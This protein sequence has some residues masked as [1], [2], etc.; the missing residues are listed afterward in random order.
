MLPLKL[1]FDGDDFTSAFFRSNVSFIE[2]SIEDCD[3]IIGTGL[4]FGSVIKKDVQKVLDKYGKYS[5]K[6]VLFFV[7]DFE[8]SLHVPSN[9]LLF[10]TSILKSLKKE[11]EFIL[12]YIWEEIEGITFQTLPK[13]NQPI[14]GFCGNIKHNIGKRLTTINKFK[15]DTRFV[16]KFILRQGFWGGKPNDVNYKTDYIENIKEAHFSICNRGKG[17]FT[18]RLY[19]VLSLGRIPILI[20]SDM[21]YPFEDLINWDEF[22]VKAKKQN[23]LLEKTFNFWDSKNN[24]QLENAQLKAKEIFDNYFTPKAFGNK[25]GQLL[26]NHKNFVPKTT[27]SKRFNFPFLNFLNKDR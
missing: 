4:V 3:Y 21:I 18:I 10:R 22:M 8:K 1:F 5:K 14:V 20:D 15:S 24:S 19:Q 2:T 12:P 11:N 27:R 16:S 25:L 23:L 6:V 7:S 26:V 13:L 17:N 9:I